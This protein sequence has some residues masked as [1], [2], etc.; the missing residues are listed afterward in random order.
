MRL[1]L[2]H[3]LRAYM[4]APVMV[5]LL[6]AG[7]M[8]SAGAAPRQAAAH[9][10]AH[11]QRPTHTAAPVRPAILSAPLGTTHLT[12]RVTLPETSIDGPALASV[13][14]AH[15]GSRSVIGWTG[16]D[17]AHHLNV[18]TSFDGLHFSD[19]RIL[20]ETSPFRPDVQM[21][22]PGSPVTIAWT[23]SDRNHSLNVLYDVYGAFG[24]PKKLT[25]SSESSFT[26][27]AL[28]VMLGSPG[29]GSSGMFLAWTGN[30][31]NH[32]L[33]IMSITVANGALVP[34]PH[35][36]L[37]QF[38][39]NAGPHLAW[40]GS[41]STV[42]LNWTSRAQQLKVATS[43]DGVTFSPSQGAGLPEASAFAPDTVNTNF[44]GEANPRD[45]IGW[46]GTDPAHHLNLQ[47]TLTFPQFVNPAATKTVLS[48][49]ALGGPALAFNFGAQIAWTGTDAAHHLNVAKFDFS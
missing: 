18:E 47:W 44:F 45:W 40:L 46:T 2:Q 34:G 23:G 35:T 5:A 22:A 30:D 14:F 25:L 3:H 29:Q 26:A 17:P 27:P 9:A 33:N 7:V 36:V 24:T 43:P 15:I 49:T 16:T 12:D 6:T 38:S 37:P 32:S 39:S 13:F 1:Y 20:T 48:D 21:S 41:S 11:F 8:I 19:K 31:T 10:L 42:V 4:V 28:L